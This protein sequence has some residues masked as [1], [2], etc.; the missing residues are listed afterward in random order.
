MEAILGGRMEVMGQGYTT[1]DLG[2]GCEDE[3]VC[4]IDMDL[5]GDRR[6][7]KSSMHQVFNAFSNKHSTVLEK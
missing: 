1:I 2:S 5:L 4:R 3:S 7:W 6:V